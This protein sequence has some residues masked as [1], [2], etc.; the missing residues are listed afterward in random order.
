MYVISH[1]HTRRFRASTHYRPEL[2]PEERAVRL[3]EMLN[4]V[5]ERIFSTVQM[6]H[7]DAPR[8]AFW[9]ANSSELLHFLK[10]DRHITS[11]SLQAQDILAETVHLAFK[12]LVL[13][14]QTDLKT[15][16]PQ[17]LLDADEASPEQMIPSVMNVLSLAMNLL[18]KCRVNAALTI[19]LF[20]QLFHFVNM[21]TFNQGP[22][23]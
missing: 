6:N 22:Y 2:V 14:L 20:S 17:M 12:Q 13:C 23:S 21:W 11:F 9:M 19:Q 18:R 7:L 4:N 8:L 3:T 1:D 10:S 5:A 16:M 15:A